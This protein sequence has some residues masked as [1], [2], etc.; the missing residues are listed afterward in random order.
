MRWL[1]VTGIV[2]FHLCGCAGSWRTTKVVDPPAG[3]F[4]QERFSVRVDPR[5]ELLSIIFYLSE[6]REYQDACETPYFRAVD[7]HFGRNRKH[8]AVEATRDLRA[9][10]S[11]SFNAPIDLSAHL[12]SAESLHL[13]VP[14]DPHPQRLDGRWKGA[15]LEDYLKKV[16]DFA[17]QTGFVDFMAGQQ[18]YFR[19]VE[20]RYAEALDSEGLLAW[21][22]GFFGP[23][24]NVR[25]IL[26]PGLL[27]GPHGY[28]TSVVLPDGREV[29]RP[30][31]GL[32]PCDEKGLPV[33]EDKENL[34]AYLQHEIAHAYVN[35]AVNANAE[36]LE[37]IARR[38]YRHVEAQ[39]DEQSYGNWMTMLYESGVRASTILFLR[40]RYGEAA[41]EKALARD[42]ARSFLWLRGMVEL[43]DRYRKERDRY[44]S[45]EAFVPEW[46]PVLDKWEKLPPGQKDPPFKGPVNAAF[47]RRGNALLIAP[48]VVEGDE[49]SRASARFVRAIHKKIFS[50]KGI[51]MLNA[52]KVTPREVSTRALFLYG[53]PDTNPVLAQML[54]KF[55]WKIKED[56][57]H[58]GARKFSGQ[59]LVLI[60]CHP[61]PENKR[62]PVTV[63][64]AAR[65]E[66][67]VEI[68]SIFHGPTDWIIARRDAEGNFEK[69]A[70]GDFEKTPDGQWLLR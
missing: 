1:L 30:V 67:L 57:I 28:G 5:V 66:N 65:N 36:L 68:N 70:S 27:N 41:A 7:N 14:L 51:P 56:G 26:V 54:E 33:I 69:V 31:L 44:E 40:D 64:T 9:I 62:L 10:H 34:A 19:A 47:R 46:V 2:W 15:P 35:P 59:N 13:V 20:A 17:K 16:R 3:F 49:S 52:A 11:I 48:L 32:K 63:Y 42:E 58:L 6:A 8:A 22:D 23:R 24:S 4:P 25:F 60:A 53:T 45:F 55:G 61:H 50:K 38:V 12:D 21:F 37:P 18:A 39:M 29:I 43:F